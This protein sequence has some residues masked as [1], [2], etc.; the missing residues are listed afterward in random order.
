VNGLDPLGLG[1][2]SWVS[3]TV[4]SGIDA[5]NSWLN[6]ESTTLLCNNLGLQYSVFSTPAG[7]G[8]EQADPLQNLSLCSFSNTG[9][10]G[11]ANNAASAC[12]PSGGRGGALAGMLRDGS[13]AADARAEASKINIDIPPDYVASPAI[14]S[15]GWVFRPPGQSGGDQNSIRVMEEGAD[16]VNYPDGYARVFNSNGHATDLNGKQIGSKGVGQEETHFPLRPE[17]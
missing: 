14:P 2:W 9:A 15:P 16:P 1:P 3:Q 8:P 6:N 7:C 13:S 12:S 11:A 17:E 10:C 4:A 5:T